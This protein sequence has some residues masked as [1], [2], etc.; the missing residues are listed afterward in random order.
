MVKTSRRPAVKTLTLIKS[1]DIV[2]DKLLKPCQE[3]DHS[4]C[5]GWAA[6]NRKISPIN[7]NYFLKCICICHKKKPTTAGSAAATPKNKQKRQSS[8]KKKTK[9]KKK[10][11]T[12]KHDRKMSRRGRKSKRVKTKR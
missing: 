10:Q 3:D 7:A 1:R 4:N 11:S 12:Q 5:T 6:L 2:V 9:G 8:A